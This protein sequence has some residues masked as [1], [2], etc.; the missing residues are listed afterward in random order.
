M[1]EVMHDDLL[2]LYIVQARGQKEDDP[3]LVK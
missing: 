3:E 1:Q 2:S